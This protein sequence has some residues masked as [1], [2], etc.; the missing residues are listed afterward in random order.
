MA[1]LR[2][3]A[4][5]ALGLVALTLTACGERAPD[6]ATG[7]ESPPAAPAATP[8]APTPATSTTPAATASFRYQL[9]GVEH[10]VETIDGVRTSGGQATVSFGGPHQSG[11]TLTVKIMQFTGAGAYPIAMRNG[12]PVATIAVMRT[13]AAGL[14]NGQAKLDAGGEVK[15]TEY[16][17]ATGTIS[18]TFSGTVELGGRSSGITDGR[19]SSVRL[20]SM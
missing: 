11:T 6:S 13:S 4:S 10:A 15:V 1:S 20:R 3:L 8:A 2:L 18:G 16:D 14:V 9:D 17:E 12:A 7:A 19:F 5:V